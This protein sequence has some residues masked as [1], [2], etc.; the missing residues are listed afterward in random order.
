M[1]NDESQGFLGT[2]NFPSGAPGKYDID[3][4]FDWFPDR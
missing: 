2:W 4:R 1:R 3:G